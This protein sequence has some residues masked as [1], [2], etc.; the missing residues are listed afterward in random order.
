MLGRLISAMDDNLLESLAH[1][2]TFSWFINA[3]FRLYRL[4]CKKCRKEVQKNKDRG[5]RTVDQGKRTEKKTTDHFDQPPA[6]TNQPER[7][8]FNALLHHRCNTQRVF[9]T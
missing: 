8:N 9:Y 4:K 5:N 7:E 3:N 2:P 1:N 6:E